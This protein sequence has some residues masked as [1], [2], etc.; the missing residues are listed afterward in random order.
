MLG[1]TP[2]YVAS[3][4]SGRCGKGRPSW[5]AAGRPRETD[6]ASWEQ[7]RAWRA[8]G[9]RD[10]EI[11]RRLGVNQS[12]VLRR[13]GRAHVQD[14]LPQA[15]RPEPEAAHTQAAEPEPEERPGPGEPV[16][17][18]PAADAERPRGR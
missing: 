11:A 12:T 3:C 16:P 7:A 2:S 8:E 17:P 18:Q 14:T 6:D 9:A 4:G 13:L 10:A 5:S 1:L 15:P